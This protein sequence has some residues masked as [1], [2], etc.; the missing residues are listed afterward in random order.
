MSDQLADYEAQLQ[1]V[2]AAI[3]AEPD[4]EELQKLKEDLL[5]VINL[6]KELLAEGDGAETSEPQIAPKK[7]EKK[8]SVMASSVGLANV[9]VL[10]KPV[11]DWRPGD[12]CLAVWSK[13]GK[14]YEANIEAVNNQEAVVQFVGF[15]TKEINSLLHLRKLNDQEIMKNVG[16]QSKIKLFNEQLAK[17]REKNLK[18][19]Q[20]QKQLEQAKEHEKTKWND[21]SK[22]ATAKSM[23]GVR[24]PPTAAPQAVETKPG[25]TTRHVAGSLPR[26]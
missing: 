1:H 9:P 17:K 3:L 6:S 15:D 8:A 22:K 18:R 13:N 21:F 26:F 10:E 19:L 24:R 7:A 14:H 2:E 20:K 16:K 12:R 4:N 25:T 5:E 23:K 11:R